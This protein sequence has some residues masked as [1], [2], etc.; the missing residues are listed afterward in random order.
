[1]YINQRTCFLYC[2][3]HL[4]KHIWG[5]GRFGYKKVCCVSARKCVC[6]RNKISRDVL[7][8]RVKPIAAWSWPQTSI[9]FRNLGYFT[10]QIDA[11]ELFIWAQQ[12]PLDQ[13][14]LL[15]EFS[16]L[17]TTTHHRRQ[18]SSGRAIGPSQR[19]PAQHSRQTDI[20]ASGGIRTHNLS[21]RAAA[22]LRLRPRG[23]W[24]RLA[25]LYFKVFVIKF[26]NHAWRSDCPQSPRSVLT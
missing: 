5:T 13:G 20:H 17:H 18:D 16:R 19:L 22:D 10:L 4:P 21:R 23:H 12:P 3:Y 24:D 1:M 8:P 25:E 6:K 9:K 26:E 14:L 7:V 15:H 11:A 2:V